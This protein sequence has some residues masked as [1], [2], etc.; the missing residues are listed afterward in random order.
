MTNSFMNTKSKPNLITRAA[1]LMAMGLLGA[2]SYAQADDVLVYKLSANRAWRQNVALN[3]GRPT[4]SGRRQQ[5]GVMR[6]TSYLVL[7]LTTR[8]VVLVDYYTRTVDGGRIKEFTV[9]N[10]AYADWTGVFPTQP[11]EALMVAAPGQANKSFSLKKADQDSTSADF[12][13]D[14]E[15]DSSEAGS[16]SYLVGVASSR[17]LGTVTVPNVAATM[18]GA[19]RVSEEVVYGPAL[20]VIANRFPFARVF[21]RG[22]GAQT[23]TLDTRLTTTALNTAPTDPALTVATTA[24]AVSLVKGVLDRAGYED[25]SGTLLK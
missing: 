13:R 1:T 19:K 15:V 8:D 25:A 21:Y 2:G 12:N 4:E 9:T 14:G 24:Y 3:P 22:N 16:V 10:E 18:R 6:D 5:A 17:R 11:W 7:N 23:A 20:D